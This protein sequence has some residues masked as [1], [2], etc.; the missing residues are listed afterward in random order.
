M[1]VRNLA[2]AEAVRQ[3]VLAETPVASLNLIELDLSPLT[4]I[5]NFAANFADRGL[6]LNILMTIQHTPAL[7]EREG[8]P[9]MDT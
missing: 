6:P 3:V 4:S 9:L 7:S 5:R 8:F 2:A 1:A